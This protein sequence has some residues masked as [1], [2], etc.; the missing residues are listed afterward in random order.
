MLRYRFKHWKSDLD[1]PVPNEEI[2]AFN[3]MHE[4]IPPNVWVVL[5]GAS[6]HVQSVVLTPVR[7]EVHVTVNLKTKAEVDEEI[8]DFKQKMGV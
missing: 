5:A 7:L 6:F 4:V 8:W 3:I 2:Y 1:I